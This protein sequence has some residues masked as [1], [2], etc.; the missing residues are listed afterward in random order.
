VSPGASLSKWL[1]RMSDGRLKVRIAAAA[2][3]GKANAALI[4]FVARSLGIK[5]T[6]VRLVS[7]SSS[8]DKIVEVDAPAGRIEELAKGD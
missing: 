4:E 5:K 8:R 1:G 2:E 3:S 6:A 7:G